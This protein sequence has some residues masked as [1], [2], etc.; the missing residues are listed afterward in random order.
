M[1]NLSIM[2]KIE[3]MKKR[4]PVYLALRQMNETCFNNNALRT[5]IC[6][7]IM[8]VESFYFKNR[9]EW[10]NWLE[11][12][13]DKEQRVWLVHFKKN[14]GKAS[15]TL[16]DAV[17]EALCFGW[18]DS[19]LKTINEEQF[20]LKYTPRKIKSVWS[21]INKE[22][23]EKLI[24]S[25][26]M[27]EAGLI[28]IEGARKHGLWNTAYTSKKKDRIPSDLK[29]ALLID[30]KAWN[31]FQKFANSYR[32]MYIGWIIGARTGETRR[33]RITQVVKRSALNKK[34]GVE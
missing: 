31:N 2:V 10:R 6:I 18:I 23:A 1:L 29:E 11:K 5:I 24:E 27:T 33:K 15:I 28:K 3:F 17:E 34:P 16:N 13:H 12:N 14:S 22:R 25:G 8:D 20:I 32:N 19:K 4:L 7:S 9:Q 21:K 26:R 30:K